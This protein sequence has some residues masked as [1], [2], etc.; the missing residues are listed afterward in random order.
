[1][2]A[3]RCLSS[4]EVRA[5]MRAMAP[6]TRPF[7]AGVLSLL[8]CAGSASAHMM[9]A[10]QGTL[11]VIDNAVFEVVAVPVSA[12]HGVDE[13]GDGRLSEQEVSRHQAE[14]QQQVGSRFRLYEDDT[15]NWLGF[16]ASSGDHPAK[17]GVQELVHLRAEHDERSESSQAGAKQILALLK[18]SFPTPPRSLRLV[19][20]L[21]GT[22]AGE[23]QLTIR[24][25]RGG[26]PAEVAVLRP[27][28]KEHSFFR[29]PAKLFADFV[30]L[31]IEHILLGIDHLL[32]LLTVLIGVTGWRHWIAVLTTFTVAHSITLSLA[33]LGLA[34][35]PARIVEPLIAASIVVMAL[36]NLRRV[37]T[38]QGRRIAVVFACGLLH[39]LGFAS[40][41]TE[42]GV[43]AA[44][45]AVSLLGFNVG[46][47]MGQALFLGALLVV[48]RILLHR[49]VLG[50]RL[51]FKQPAN[52]P[53]DSSGKES[54]YRLES[55]VQ[56][57]SIMAA[58]LGSLWFVHRLL[59]P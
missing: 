48:A 31:G 9:P 56:A 55:L 5:N 14:L 13:D 10:Q 38:S 57:C 26:E 30:A 22:A 4:T 11:N 41:M 51:L 39:G 17:E 27:L 36:L 8:L 23:G 28:A 43:T 46:I 7:Q 12:L 3:Q 29:S 54:V 44:R 20:D 19:T 2:I 58:V 33:V 25:T 37:Q 53:G 6:P 18:T 50:G 59:I 35:A 34:K 47:E 42:M 40:A 16:P 52:S 24:A 1:M 49:A 45:R 32:F 15:R 21:F